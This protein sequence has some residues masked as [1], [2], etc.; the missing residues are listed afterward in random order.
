VSFITVSDK[1]IKSNGIY[2]L[3]TNKIKWN[4]IVQNLEYN[5]YR[6]KILNFEKGEFN[7]KVVLRYTYRSTPINN[8]PINCKDNT[9]KRGKG[10]FDI[11]FSL[12]NI[13]KK[14]FTFKRVV[15]SDHR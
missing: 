14:F 15:A 2:N 10:S 13:L 3:N 11:L 8:R 7:G 6:E 9:S 1:D 4:C 5:F 12:A